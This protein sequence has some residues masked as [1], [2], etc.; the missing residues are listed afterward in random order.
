MSKIIETAII[1]HSKAYLLKDN[2]T[3]DYLIEVLQR[4]YSL[5][6]LFSNIDSHVD[7]E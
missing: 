6:D 1:L 2:R 5:L 7:V 3:L 4:Y